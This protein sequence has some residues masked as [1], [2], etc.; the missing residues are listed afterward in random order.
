MALAVLDHLKDLSQRKAS[1]PRRK[2]VT[3]PLNQELIRAVGEL[4]VFSNVSNEVGAFVELI[5][6]NFRRGRTPEIK[7]DEAGHMVGAKDGTLLS[8]KVYG[9]DEVVVVGHTSDLIRPS[10][11]WHESI[12]CTI[13]D[14]YPVADLKRTALTRGVPALLG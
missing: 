5:C 13:V 9:P 12:W 4:A 2:G 14:E 8:E 11:E 1:Q 10:E 6:S 3:R 7:S